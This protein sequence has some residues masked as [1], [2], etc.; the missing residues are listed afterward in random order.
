MMNKRLGITRLILILMTCCLS[1][2]VYAQDPTD[3][4]PGDPGAIYVFTVQNLQ[5]GTFAQ[6]GSGGTVTV[7]NNGS[8][9]ATGSIILINQGASFFQAII[10]VE[11]APGSL[12]SITNGADATLTGS[13]GGT[14][15][16]TIGNSDPT[17][18]FN[19]TVSPP[20]R[21]PVNIGGTLTIGN[22]AASPPG[23]YTGV[24]YITF[25]QE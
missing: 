14:V 1:P 11:A 16:L 9:S 5:F 6:G 12:I 20:S 10:D 25:N 17:S 21:T 4:L 8:R 7:S 13:N 23:T 15:T 2:V 18:P 22:P 24:F 19:T 3:T